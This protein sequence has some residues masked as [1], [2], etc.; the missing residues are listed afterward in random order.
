[1]RDDL[2]NTSDHVPFQG[3]ILQRSG[4]TLRSM[5]T[6]VSISSVATQ[7]RLLG[8]RQTTPKQLTG[9]PGLTFKHFLKLRYT[10]RFWQKAQ[11]K[12]AKPLQVPNPILQHGK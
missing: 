3:T 9:S 2:A 10:S 8:G 1:M 5:P 11:R 4:K 12:K 6:A 7:D